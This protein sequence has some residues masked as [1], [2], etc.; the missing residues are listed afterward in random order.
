MANQVKYHG[1]KK[2]YIIVQKSRSSR[3]D[4]LIR[5]HH[6]L[7][8]DKCI[9]AS[10]T[11]ELFERLLDQVADILLFLLRIVDSVTQIYCI[12]E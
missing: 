2:K 10:G 4:A 6:I 5:R 8:V 1:S 7:Y 3:H 11:F 12:L 9:L